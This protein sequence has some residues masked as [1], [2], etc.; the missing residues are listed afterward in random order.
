MTSGVTLGLPSRSPPTQVPKRSGRAVGG[1]LDAQPGRARRLE[2]LEQVGHDRRRPARRG[3]HRIDQPASSAGVGPLV[4]QLVGLP[5]EVDQLGQPRRS[6]RPARRSVRQSSTACPAARRC[7]GGWR[8]APARRLGGMGGEDRAGLQALDHSPRPGRAGR[9]RRDD[10]VDRRRDPLAA[11]LRPDPPADVVDLLGDVGQVEP[12]GE[13]AGQ[14]DRLR[15]VEAGQE[16]LELRGPALGRRARRRARPAGAAR[17]PPGG[18]WC[19][20]E[21]GSARSWTGSAWVC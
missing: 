7:R 10:A 19:R 12:D 4:A 20:P 1:Q 11:A 2:V 14:A 5:Q 8:A 21:G 18:R 3:S 9:R 15:H 13:R 6:T 17:R 16:L